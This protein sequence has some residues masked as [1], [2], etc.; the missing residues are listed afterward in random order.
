V[1]DDEEGAPEDEEIEVGAEAELEVPGGELE[2]GAEEEELMEGLLDAAGV[3]LVD[4][5]ALV[6][7]ITKRVAARIVKEALKAKK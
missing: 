1:V 6:E 2:M 3:E 4:T 7:K 5:S